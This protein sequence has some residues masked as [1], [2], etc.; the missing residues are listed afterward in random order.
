[1]ISD[2]VHSRS[3]DWNVCEGFQTLLTT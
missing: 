3:I 1:M 2:R